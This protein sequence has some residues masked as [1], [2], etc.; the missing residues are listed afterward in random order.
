VVFGGGGWVGGRCEHPPDSNYPATMG[1]G[2][3]VRF[4]GSPDLPSG[5]IGDLLRSRH[6]RRKRHDG[7]DAVGV[8]GLDPAAVEPHGARHEGIGE[9]QRDI[10]E[11]EEDQTSRSHRP[12]W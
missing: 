12:Q 3:L 4:T 5:A 10:Q 11:Q 6:N 1:L 9:V 7:T 2:D 8:D